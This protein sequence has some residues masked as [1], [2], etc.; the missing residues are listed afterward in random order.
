M[1]VRAVPMCPSKRS[2][3][4]D[5]TDTVAGTSRHTVDMM[6]WYTSNW[7]WRPSTK[8]VGT[9]G[10]VLL[11]PSVSTLRNLPPCPEKG[12][13]GAAG[14]TSSKGS[15]PVSEVCAGSNVSLTYWYNKHVS[16]C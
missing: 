8:R 3:S 1:L 16:N 11:L 4:L 10:V 13:D 15:P 9:L 6:A 2:I 12:L 5:S 14:L 7:Y